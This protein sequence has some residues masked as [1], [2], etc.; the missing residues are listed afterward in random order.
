MESEVSN[1][2]NQMSKF[3]EFEEKKPKEKKFK[4][5]RSKSGF[6]LSLEKVAEIKKALENFRNSKRGDTSHLS[7]L[8]DVFK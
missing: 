7:V 3:E 1:S 5:N 4:K 2:D 8:N 6:N